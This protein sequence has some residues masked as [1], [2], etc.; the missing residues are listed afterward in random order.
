MYAKIRQSFSNY[1]DRHPAA[2]RITG[3]LRKRKWMLLT[4]FITFAHVAS[5]L[6][7]VRAIMEVRTAQG[8]I[9]WAIAL[10]SMPYL[11]VPA[12]WV[13]GRS[14]FQGYVLARRKDRA[15]IDPTA[16]Q[17]LLDLKNRRLLAPPS[18]DS[19]LLIEKLAMMRFTNGN[20]A[21]LLQDGNATFESVFERIE[22]AKEYLLVE[23]Y[24]IRDDTLGR[25]LKHRLVEKARR[26]IRVYMLYDEVG[27]SDLPARFLTGMRNAGIDVR[28]FNTTQGRANRW[29]LN[30][31]NHRKIVV[32]DGESAWVGG[33][34]V[35]DEYMGRDPKI[36]LWRD[37]HVKVTGPVVKGVQVAFLEDWHWASQQ[38]LK[39]N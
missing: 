5:A 25:E 1:L 24:I 21:E 15:Q 28:R 35:G 22:Q 12:Y 38:L 39:L 3:R 6:T 13:F 29:Q 23:F 17:Y 30:F 4:W 20:D 36:G 32:V 9:A 27:N 34:N 10:N 18:H 7:S 33:L 19:A 16:R 11:S 14:K 2:K 31:R 8:A 37:T 26:G